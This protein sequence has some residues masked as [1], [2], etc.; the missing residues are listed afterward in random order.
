M[1]SLFLMIYDFFEKRK[2]LFYILSG[3]TTCVL[4]FFALQVKVQQNVMHMLP[5]DGK[6]EQFNKFI[7]SSKF[8]D[9]VIVC[10]SPNDTTIALETDSL[11]ACADTFVLQMQQEMGEYISSLD[12]MADD[13]SV[14]NLLGNR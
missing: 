1:S 7:Q 8:S 12:Y 2:G 10:I 4:A 13:T 3:I 6:T 9:R 5:S 11:V 14:A